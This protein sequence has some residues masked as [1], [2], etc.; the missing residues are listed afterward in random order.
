MSILIYA[1]YLHHNLCVSLQLCGWGGLVEAY[2]WITCMLIFVVHSIISI[3]TSSPYDIMVI[4]AQFFDAGAG[5]VPSILDI[6]LL[7]EILKVLVLYTCLFPFMLIM[8]PVMF[9]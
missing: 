2:G 9:I 5:Y 6:T 8:N 7:D 1:V 4:H 3:Y